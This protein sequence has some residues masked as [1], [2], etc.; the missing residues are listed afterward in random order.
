[1][2]GNGKIGIRKAEKGK[3]GKGKV[4]TKIADNDWECGMCSQI[5]SDNVQARNGAK[6][7]QC[8]FC[9]VPHLNTCLEIDLEEEEELYFRCQFCL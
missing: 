7:I 9:I 1:M 5:Y 6:W 3:A 4:I 8:Y 2:T